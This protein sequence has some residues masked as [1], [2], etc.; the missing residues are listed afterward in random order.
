MKKLNELEK[1]RIEKQ[2]ENYYTKYYVALA[3][4]QT[5]QTKGDK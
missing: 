3:Q 4:Q 2:Y 1:K 5:K